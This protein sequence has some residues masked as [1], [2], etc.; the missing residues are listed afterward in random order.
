MKQIE[1]GKTRHFFNEMDKGRK[2]RKRYEEFV[3]SEEAKYKARKEEELLRE[4]D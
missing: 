2:V 4:E 3:E 1:E